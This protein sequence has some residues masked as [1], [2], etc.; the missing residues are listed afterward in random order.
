MDDNPDMSG[1]SWAQKGGNRG[2]VDFPPFQMSS[3]VS[4]SSSTS[5]STS[6]SPSPSP[7]PPPLCAD[8]TAYLRLLLWAP[9]FIGLRRTRTL[10]RG[11][12]SLWLP[13][14]NEMPGKMLKQMQGEK[15]CRIS[16]GMSEYK[17]KYIYYICMYVGQMQCQNKS[18]IESQTE[19]RDTC[20]RCQI[21]FL[22]LRQKCP[23]ICHVDVR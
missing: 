19:C 8:S 13:R 11:R 6:P 3:Q 23:N 14:Q 5:S 18:Q 1:S 17:Y 16:D 15:C 7:S 12:S 2:G 10:S 21:E 4:Q 22:N 20:Q 9:A